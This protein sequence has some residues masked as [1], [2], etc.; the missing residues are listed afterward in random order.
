MNHKGGRDFMICKGCGAEFSENQTFCPHCGHKNEASEGTKNTKKCLRCGKEFPQERYF[1]DACGGELAEITAIPP[2]QMPPNQ[3]PSNQIPPY[4]MPSGQ[5]PPNQIPPYQIPPNQVPPNQVP[6]NQVPP[7]QM[8]SYQMPPYQMPPGQGTPNQMPPNQI[9]PN[10][11]N[12]NRMP[13]IPPLPPCDSIGGNKKSKVL[14]PAIIAI[15]AILVMAVWAVAIFLFLDFKNKNKGYETISSR[16]EEDTTVEEQMEDTETVEE[17]EDSTLTDPEDTVTGEDIA[18][19]PTENTGYNT[20]YSYQ[21]LPDVASLDSDVRFTAYD[22]YSYDSVST[23]VYL[24]NDMGVTSSD[25]YLAVDDYCTMLQTWNGF[26]YEQEFSDE[27]YS[28]TGTLTD[29]LSRDNICLG[30]TASIEDTGYYVYI[31]VYTL[32]ETADNTASSLSFENYTTYIE[33]RD[34]QYFDL[35][36][37]TYMENGMSF[38][39]YNVNVTDLGDGTAVLDANFDLGAYTPNWYFYVNDFVVLPRDSQGNVLSDVCLAEYVTDSMGSTVSTPFLINTD[40]YYN[41]TVSF[42]VPANTTSFTIYGTNIAN[43]QFA[44]PVYYIDMELE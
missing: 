19:D 20:V 1:C 33:G 8:Q 32:S 26:Y 13:P 36:T 5:I 21:E 11:M 2:Y 18:E 10:Q 7:S 34:S 35:N 28:E 9:P 17:S 23:Y 25:F 27:Q 30:I 43:D 29:Y 41:Y 12:P 38:Y 42:L 22:H 6:P 16:D 40:Y 14:V 15:V 39:L 44:G 37:E 4:Q 24:F 31:A 3:V